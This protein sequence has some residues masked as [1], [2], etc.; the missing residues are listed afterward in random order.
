MKFTVERKTLI[1]MLKMLSVG[2]AERDARLRIV[3]EINNAVQ[4]HGGWPAVSTGR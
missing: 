2:G 1:K 3:P 4:Q